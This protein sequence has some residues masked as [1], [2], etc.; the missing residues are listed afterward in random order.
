VRK[1]ADRGAIIALSPDGASVLLAHGPGYPVEVLDV[2]TGAV[3]ASLDVASAFTTES[4][5]RIVTLNHAGSWE[6]DWAVAQGTLEPDGSA[7]VT[8]HV[9][10]DSI[11][12]SDIV[13]FPSAVFP[14]S[15]SEPQLADSSGTR[16]V[17]WAPLP[18]K[19]G[20]AKDMLYTYLDCSTTTKACV[21]G[22][23][24][25]SLI[26]HPL[27]NPSRPEGVGGSDEG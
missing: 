26:F 13:E 17:A 9:T 8:L 16:V 15:V 12:I 10:K 20:Q 27:Y 21:Q 2:A 11:V 23:P 6:G 1:L 19:G 22:P 4:G 25:G 18:G 7:I 24:Q 14:M 3:L 5:R